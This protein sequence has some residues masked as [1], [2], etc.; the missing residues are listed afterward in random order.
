VEFVGILITFYLGVFFVSGF[1]VLLRADRRDVGLTRSWSAYAARRG[2]AFTRRR[3]PDRAFRIEGSRDGI[4]FQLETDTGRRLVTRLIAQTA[5]PA[6]GRM[7][8]SSGQGRAGDFEGPRAMTGDAAF[9][10][11]FYVRASDARDAETVLRPAVRRA[12]QQF[13]MPMVGAGLRLVVDGDEVVV[14]WAGGEVDAPRIDAAHAI[15]REVCGA[16]DP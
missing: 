9:D 14:E 13:P 5:S 12:L 10:P 15:L 7:V 8:A 3:T 11:R 4:A 16:P 6:A 2:Y 1:V